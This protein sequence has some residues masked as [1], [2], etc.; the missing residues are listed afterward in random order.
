MVTGTDYSF[1][2]LRRACNMHKK[3]SKHILL[4]LICRSWY[5]EIADEYLK[6]NDF[7]IVEVDWERPARMPYEISAKSTKDVGKS[8]FE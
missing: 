8:S 4:Y 5:K 6:N 2:K 3:L 7:N 1:F